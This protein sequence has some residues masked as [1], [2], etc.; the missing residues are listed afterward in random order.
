MGEKVL[1]EGKGGTER[2][3]RTK[4]ERKKENV[5]ERRMEREREKERER[6]RKREG[7]VKEE[8]NCGSCARVGTGW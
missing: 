5:N 6:E 3:G 2:C 7:G 8:E 1:S 4:G